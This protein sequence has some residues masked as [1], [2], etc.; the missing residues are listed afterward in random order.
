MCALA[1]LQAVAHHGPAA[2]SVR[3]GALSGQPQAQLDGFKSRALRA[4]AGAQRNLYTTEWR[5]IKV[6][7]DAGAEVLVISDDGTVDCERLLSEMSHAE[8]VAALH[9]GKWALIALAVATQ[10]GCLTASPL[11][12]LEAALALV[13]TQLTRLAVRLRGGGP[14]IGDTNEQPAGAPDPDQAQVCRA[15]PDLAHIEAPR[16]T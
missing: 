11:T 9:G 15:V 6:A 16:V 14:P 13:Q 7:G 12:A 10:H 8:L 5:R 4:G 1:C 2:V 3:L